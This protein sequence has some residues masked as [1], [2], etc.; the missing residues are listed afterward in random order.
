MKMKVTEIQGI[1]DQSAV[2]MRNAILDM[3]W[4]Y[5]WP[6]LPSHL[7]IEQFPV[8]EVLYHFCVGLL[9]SNPVMK[10]P[11]PRV[12]VLV[13]SFSEDIIYAVTCGKTKPPKHVLL[14]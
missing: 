9:T 12:K 5:S 6:I 13:Q 2:Y 14:S 1:V 7:S 10:N 8:P 3:K 4:A 11:S